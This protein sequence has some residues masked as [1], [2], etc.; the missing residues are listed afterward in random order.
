[1]DHPESAVLGT[2]SRRSRPLPLVTA[3]AS[4]ARGYGLEM[5]PTAPVFPEVG[6]EEI[7]FAAG[8]GDRQ[9]TNSPYYGQVSH[10]DRAAAPH[11]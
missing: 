10:V 4:L 9:L 7:I 5:A 8:I 2:R 1:M 3:H 11:K 6:F